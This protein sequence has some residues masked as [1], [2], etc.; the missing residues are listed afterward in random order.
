MR[1]YGLFKKFDNPEHKKFV[2]ARV[3]KNASK[4]HI[5]LILSS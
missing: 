4:P 1:C 5:L 2:A 3:Y